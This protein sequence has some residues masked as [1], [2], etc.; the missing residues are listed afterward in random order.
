MILK[1][2]YDIKGTLYV[3]KS[4]Y[5]KEVQEVEEIVEEDINYENNKDRSLKL[6]DEM[7]EEVKGKRSRRAKQTI[8]S[9][10]GIVL[11]I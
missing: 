11:K 4:M 8:I 5:A 7:V 3:D 9:K 2:L 10:N 6:H 1:E